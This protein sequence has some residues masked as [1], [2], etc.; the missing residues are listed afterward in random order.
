LWWEGWFSAIRGF[1]FSTGL[2]RTLGLEFAATFAILLSV[3]QILAYSRGMRPALDYAATGKPR[4]TRRHAWG[5][6]VR[7]LGYTV[8]ALLCSALVQHVDHAWT[9]AIRIGLVIGIVTGMG[10][11]IVP[12]IEYYADNLPERR[13]GA[14]GIGL[15]L[16]GFALQSFQYWLVLLDVRL[17]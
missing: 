3:G 14:F 11:A 2:Y 7:T 8:T 15:I 10:G 13:L 17:T 12:L 6:L 5:I 16:C 1:A 9:F 4:I